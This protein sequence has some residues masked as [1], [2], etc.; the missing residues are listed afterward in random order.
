MTPREKKCVIFLSFLTTWIAWAYFMYKPSRY[1]F[2][3]QPPERDL[4]IKVP[5]K[6]T[7]GSYLNS[8]DSTNPSSATSVETSKGDSKPPEPPR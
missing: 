4:T 6:Y 3:P 5:L 7:N 1:D 8:L 2:K